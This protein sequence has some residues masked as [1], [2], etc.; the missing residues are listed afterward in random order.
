MGQERQLGKNEHRRLREVPS[1]DDEWEKGGIGAREQ[2][3]PCHGGV[4][5]CELP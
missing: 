4:F 1:K 3:D 2:P 5:I